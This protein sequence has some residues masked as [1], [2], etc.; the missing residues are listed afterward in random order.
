[1]TTIVIAHRLTTLMHADMIA[2]LE[3]GR[4]TQSGSHQQLLREDGLYK[5]LWH[6]QTSM[7]RDLQQDLLTG[8]PLADAARRT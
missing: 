4:V 7:Q 8:G 1:M 2:V 5:R 3:G 6:V